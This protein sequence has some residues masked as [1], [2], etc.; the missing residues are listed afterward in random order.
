MKLIPLNIQTLYADLVQQ[1]QAASPDEATVID[2]E[3][4]GHRYLRLQ[5]W[6]G[7]KR[8]S[9]QLG[10]A[11]NPEAQQR[12]ATARSELHYREQRRKTVSILRDLMQGPAT[13]L[14]KVLEA[15]SFAGLFR[16]GAVL[17]GTAAYQCYP[18]MVGCILPS[19]SQMTQDADLATADL[20]L[21]TDDE[22]STL[23]DVLQLADPSFTSVMGLD[24]RSLPSKFR[25]SNGFLVDVLT[26]MR[27]RSDANPMPLKNLRAGAV[28]LQH[29]DWLIE[30]TTQTIALH[31]HGV[32]VVVPR[33]ARYAVHKLIISQKRQGADNP[34]R[35][36]DLIQAEALMAA[37]QFADP[38]SLEDALKDARKQ[39]KKGWAEPIDKSLKE[40]ETMKRSPLR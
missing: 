27:R 6:V 8:V 32:P 4:G 9:E 10:R 22:A 16:R 17:V 33:P 12:A 13:P 26:P 1:V 24:S 38:Y 40:V 23:L 19:G 35:L 14:G 21:R 15:V 11:D 25:T 29:I 7:A 28:P 31:G 34:K 30:D 3:S 37:L 20:T 39:G 36:K 18:P 2:Y 5:R